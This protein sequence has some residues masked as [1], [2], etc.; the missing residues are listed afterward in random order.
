MTDPAR[1]ALRVAASLLALLALQ[2]PAAAAA[3][4]AY[5]IGYLA[6]EDDPR[7]RERRT[8]A[9]IVLRPRLQP[10]EGAQAA[11]RAGRVVGRALKVDF[12]LERVEGRSADDLEAGLDRL[13]S[14]MG[15]RFFLVDAPGPVVAALARRTRGRELLL[16]NVSAVDD[17]LRGEN[18]QAHL[19]HIVP[20]R[21]M[22]S[23]ALVQYAASRNWRDVLL[24]IGPEPDDETLARAFERSA[25]RFGL[26]IVE[27]RRFVATNDPRQREQNNVTLLTGNARYDLVFVADAEGDFARQ[28]PYRTFRPRPV[29]GSA[30]LVA[31][32]WHWAWERHGAPQLNQRFGRISTRRMNDFDWAAWA[33]VRVILEAMSRVR[34]TAFAPVARYL[35]GAELSF[36]NYKGTPGNFRRWDNQLRQ[37]ILLHTHNAVIARAPIEGFLHPT[38]YMDTLGVDRAETACRF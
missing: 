34:S 15:A 20:S 8:Y 5:T 25:K 21:A 1:L 22:L 30:G 11:L 31:G 14:Q 18:C 17:E 4:P 27:V 32:A 33:G 3:R 35:K 24:L 2:G 16:F 37:P 10:F 7:Y 19:M 29:I 13:Y 12:R 23:D 26:R 6:I 28:V 38:S 36:D 9:N